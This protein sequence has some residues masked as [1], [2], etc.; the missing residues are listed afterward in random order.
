M[1][2]GDGLNDVWFTMINQLQDLPYHV[3][4]YYQQVGSQISLLLIVPLQVMKG[5]SQPI[6][7]CPHA[8]ITK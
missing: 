8:L 1:D 3:Y 6:Q 2:P 7:H 5:L 4:A